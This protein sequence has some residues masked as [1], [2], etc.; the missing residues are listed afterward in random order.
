MKTLAKNIGKLLTVVLFTTFGVVA[1]AQ[2][3]VKAA[4][5]CLLHDAYVKEASKTKN[6][7]S[8]VDCYCKVCGDKKQKEKEAKL[9]AEKSAAEKKSKQ[10]LA[11]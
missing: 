4:A 6:A 9:A 11:Q 3:H 1:K 2:T 5:N 10:Q 7:V 8:C